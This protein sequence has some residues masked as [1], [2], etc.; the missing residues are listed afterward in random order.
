VHVAC[1]CVIAVCYIT[2]DGM[3]NTARYYQAVYSYN[4]MMMSPNEGL[5]EEELCF[6]EGDIIKVCNSLK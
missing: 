5:E 2:V 3:S 6:N 1:V 4:P